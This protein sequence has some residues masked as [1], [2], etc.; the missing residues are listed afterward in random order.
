MNQKLRAVLSCPRRKLDC[1]GPL[2]HTTGRGWVKKHVGKYDVPL[3]LGCNVT[4]FIVETSGA[5]E[6]RALKYVSYLT[7]RTRG[8]HAR[9]GTAYGRSRVSTTSFYAHHTQRISKA[10]VCGD[11]GGM[12]DTIR[13]RT[14][15]LLAGSAGA[16]APAATRFTA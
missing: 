16:S 12:L 9:D 10:A 4:A 6:E 5:I 14:Q 3:R 15:T 11:I 1:E 2:D 13:G 7:R 8:A